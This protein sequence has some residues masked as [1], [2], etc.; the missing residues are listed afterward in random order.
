MCNLHKNAV[1]KLFHLYKS[2]VADTSATLLF[3]LIIPLV[4][5]SRQP[6]V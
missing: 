5:R 3:I 1:H 4:L 2:R 6:Y